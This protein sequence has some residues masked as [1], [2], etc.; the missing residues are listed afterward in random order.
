M[1]MQKLIARVQAILLAP[2]TEWPVIAA[3][4]A[5][6][7]S[8]YTQ[9][10]VWLAA[11]PALA[12]LIDATIFGY[13]IP[14]AGTVRVGFATAL[15]AAVVSYV[16]SLA[17]V[18]VFALIVNLLAPTFGAQKDSLAALKVVAYSAT[19]GM[20][21]GAGTLIPALGGLIALAGALYGIY[22]LYLGLPHTMKCPPEKAVAY[23][24]VSILAAI[25]VS[26]LFWGLLGRTLMGGMGSGLSGVLSRQAAEEAAS[27]DP[28]SPLGKLEKW[29][30]QMEEAG[31]KMQAAEKS[32][33]A[34][35]QAEA[36]K[37]LVGAAAGAAG[38]TTSL[39]P[40]RLKGFLPDAL[41][42]LPRASVSSQRTSAMGLQVSKGEA[43]Y[44]AADGT[45][46]AMELEVT[47]L[48]GAQGIMMFAGWVGI[49]MERE[50]GEGYE[51]TYR[52]GNR[53]VHEE[54]DSRRATGEFSVVV[55]ERFI[56]R[57][58]GEQLTM[59][60][61]KLAIGSLDLAGLEA[62]KNEGA[63]PG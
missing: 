39:P 42:G 26:A 11:L 48:G 58:R 22:L 62:L 40:D 33:D 31:E 3:E 49:E 47:D 43:S 38:A 29:G 28:A 16:V 27:A 35:A 13:S 18:F 61:L 10:L 20:V 8:I 9:Y 15:Q 25:V 56:V 53:M 34:K 37:N 55:G 41:A 21:A 36:L 4:P 2:K 57:L 5:T 1:D 60:Q 63:T 44:R 45:G 12:G 14:F 51:K 50:T 54:W 19:A 6:T 24:A 32:G 59:A 7:G 23:T 30:Q 52:D 46:P 17:G